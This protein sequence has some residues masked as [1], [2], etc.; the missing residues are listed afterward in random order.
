MREQGAGLARQLYIPAVLCTAL[1]G[2]AAP[3]IKKGYLLFGIGAG[4]AFS[5]L[6][7]AGWRFALAGLLVLL[8]ARCKGR[9]IVP[10]RTEWWPILWLSLFQSMIQYVCY[11]IGLSA[12]T[13]TKGAVLS[14][15]QSFFA[16]I[17]AHLCLKND[18]LDRNKA[19]G[20]ALGFAGVLVLGMGGLNSFSLVGDGLVLLSAASAGAGALVSRIFTPGRDPMLLTGW[21]LLI[22]GLFLLAVGTAGGGRLT[23]V[24]LPGVLLLGYMIVLSAAAFTIWTALLGKFPVGKVSLFGFL[25]PVFGTVFS[26]LVLRENVF[27]PRNMA[28]LALVSG[29]IALSNTV[30][31][32][33]AGGEQA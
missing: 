16:L 12:T 20:C 4:Q 19:L 22:G 3:C 18:K 21:Q 29:G 26:A 23:A 33:K 14:G 10:R 13:G 1:W 2:S 31:G 6:L 30:R 17:L 25:I 8:V 32:S 27:T 11:Y 15:T 28:A 5:Q 9:R 24:T 7:F